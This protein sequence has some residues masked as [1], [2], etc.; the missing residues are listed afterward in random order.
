M[1]PVPKN[2]TSDNTIAIVDQEGNVTGIS[3]G[4]AYITV[5]TEEGGYTAVM[6]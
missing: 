4:S 2:N 6:D 3:A 5:T 1:K